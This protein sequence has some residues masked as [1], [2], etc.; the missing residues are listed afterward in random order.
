M[1]HYME[2]EIEFCKHCGKSL[3]DIVDKDV[4]ECTGSEGVIHINYMRAKKVFAELIAKAC[5]VSYREA[6][7]S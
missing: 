3:F 7:L 5:T 1:R 2:F 4:Q 6:K